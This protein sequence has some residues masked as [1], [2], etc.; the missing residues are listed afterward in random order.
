MNSKPR[1]SRRFGHS[2]AVSTALLIGCVTTALLAVD[3]D[4]AMYIGGTLTGLKEKT[5]G[6]L[7]GLNRQGSSSSLRAWEG[8]L[9]ND[10][11]DPGSSHRQGN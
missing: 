10:T 4:K 5:E 8:H 6:R 1:T 7:Q 9:P 3:G 11:Q 2:L